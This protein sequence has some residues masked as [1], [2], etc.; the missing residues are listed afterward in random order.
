M[1]HPPF[2]IT[3]IK[4][5][6]HLWRKNNLFFL[7]AVELVHIARETSC[8]PWLIGTVVEIGVQGCTYV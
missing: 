8:I 5:Y 2:F 4:N 1:L 6:L 7:S 3:Y